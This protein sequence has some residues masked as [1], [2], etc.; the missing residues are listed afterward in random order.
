MTAH[1][2]R[3][4]GPNAAHEIDMDE[5]YSRVKEAAR[6]GASRIRL[7][8]ISLTF[9]QTR[10]LEVAGYGVA[11]ISADNITWDTTKDCPVFI[12]TEVSWV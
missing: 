3:L 7:V 5:V 6:E 2:A 8:G 12:A 1:E 10:L 9:L 11:I 4:Y